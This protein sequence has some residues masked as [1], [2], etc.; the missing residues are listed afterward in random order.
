[1]FYTLLVE[2]QLQ[3]S[4]WWDFQFLIDLK[5]RRGEYIYSICSVSFK[6]T[7]C[8]S[9]STST[10]QNAVAQVFTYTLDDTSVEISIRYLANR[11]A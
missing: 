10:K 11:L 1:M 4:S 7:T 2:F 9:N 3:N 5:Q 8:T 6:Q